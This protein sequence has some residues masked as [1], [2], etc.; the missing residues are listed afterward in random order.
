MEQAPENSRT[1]P[2]STEVSPEEKAR[3]RVPEQASVPENPHPEKCI[4]SRSR[5]INKLNHI[6]FQD[7][8]VSVVFAHKKFQHPYVL[9]AFPQ[10]CRNENLVCKWASA[11]DPAVLADFFHF[12]SIYLTT[13]QQHINVKAELVGFNEKQITLVLP[14]SSREVSERKQYRFKCDAI[15]VY[16]LQNGA[17]YHGT[18]IDFCPQQLRVK[19]ATAPPQTFAWIDRQ[20]PVTL[21]L[22]R[23][24]Q[25]VFS[26]DCRIVK[27]DHGQTERQ[28]N[29]EPV[30]QRI[31]RFSPKEFRSTRQ[32]LSPSPDAVFHHP[33]FEKQITLKVSD[34][35]GAGFAVEEDEQTAVLLPGLIL[36]DL[37]LLFG[38]G[39]AIRC[40]AQVVYHKATRQTP[41]GS[42][43]RVGIAILDMRIE[44]HKKLLSLLHQA[45]D[46]HAYVCSRVD[47]DALWDFFFETGFIY[48]QK[49]EFLQNNKEQIKA[50]YQKLYQEN[51]N[52]ASHFIYQHNG[53]I[54]AHMAMLRFYERSWLIHHHAA[55]RSSYNRGG[56]MV[57]NQVGRFINDAHRLS[58]MKMDYVFCYYRPDNKFPN[59]VFG[60]VA[61]HIDRPQLCSVDQFAYYHYTRGTGNAIELP[62]GWR[63]CPV[64]DTDLLALQASYENDSGGLMLQALQLT[65]DDI[66]CGGLAERYEQIGLQ[67]SRHLFALRHK[68]YL[69][70]ILMVNVS[71]LGLNMSDLTN[72]VQFLAVSQRDL[73]ARVVQAAVE[74]AAVQLQ[75]NPIPVLVYPRQ[76]AES[77][78]IAYEKTYCLWAYSTQQLDPYF[79][80]LKRLLKFIQH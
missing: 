44:D 57:L 53:R 70:A 59:H 47:M 39:L 24:K 76:T 28:F 23:K 40:L 26:G 72:C 45:N 54:L 12:E 61:R 65:P 80:F 3:I 14:E 27:H 6:H 46:A 17:F 9:E 18:L 50:T 37:E 77:L 16:L 43:L 56:L 74:Q 5:L 15:G 21:V 62:E 4:I 66:D 13:G 11:V 73:S 7:A 78:G 29:L 30:K 55:V 51:P 64:T 63:L 41:Q 42:I 69:S 52:I 68:H 31:R 22:T 49:Y 58:T 36:P 48:P 20:E 75:S 32:R 19:V 60:G 34:I 71:D 25:T 38:D 1:L 67:R 2:P 35:S 8:T 33:L 79:R 10:P